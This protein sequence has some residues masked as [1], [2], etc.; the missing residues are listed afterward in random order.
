MRVI[1]R[2]MCAAIS[3][4]RDWSKDNTT[5]I[6]LKNQIQVWLFENLI[7][8][9]NFETQSITIS[10]GNY[11]A[12]GLTTSAT[13]RSRL[14]ALGT[15]FSHLPTVYQ[16]DKET[17]IRDVLGEILWDGQERTYPLLTVPVAPKPQATDAVLGNQQKPKKGDMVLGSKHR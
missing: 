2:E 8:T 15:L 1:E 4:K 5:V 13:T 11:V 9:I 7:A 10:N 17:Y 6:V 16:R 14:N 3:S 12:G